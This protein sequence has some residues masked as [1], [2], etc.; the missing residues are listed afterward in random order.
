MLCLLN[1]RE[2]TLDLFGFL[3]LQVLNNLL[4][5]LLLKAV[6]KDHRCL[7]I[8]LICSDCHN[9]I[10]AEMR[11]TTEDTILEETSPS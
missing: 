10:S 7:Q 2:T 4:R 8:T 1:K 3:S 9:V 6:S 11:E 5:T